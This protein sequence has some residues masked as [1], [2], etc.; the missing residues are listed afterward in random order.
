MRRLS[1]IFISWAF[2]SGFPL[3]ALI[4]R[5]TVF[6]SFFHASRLCLRLSTSPFLLSLFLCGEE[7]ILSSVIG[8][9]VILSFLAVSPLSFITSSHV[10]RANKAWDPIQDYFVRVWR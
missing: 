4:H 6:S 1:L 9:S 7:E 10:I 2:V 8:R 3:H 5:Y